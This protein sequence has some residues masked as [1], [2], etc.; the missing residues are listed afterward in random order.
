MHAGNNQG[1][2]HFDVDSDE[3]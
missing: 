1:R 2:L 3:R